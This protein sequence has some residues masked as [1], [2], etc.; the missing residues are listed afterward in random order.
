M[1]VLVSQAFVYQFDLYILG[2]K[3][4]MVP[5]MGSLF[6]FGLEATMLI[7]FGPCT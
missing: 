2:L 5:K 1:H 7:R 4:L 6:V 3:A